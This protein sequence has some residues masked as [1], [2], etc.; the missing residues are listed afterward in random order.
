MDVMLTGVLSSVIGNCIS[1]F[2]K[3]H[4]E[5]KSGI[6]KINIENIIAVAISEAIEE[7]QIS[8]PYRLEEVCIYI[9]S[10]EVMSIIRQIFSVKLI[11]GGDQNNIT[12]IESEFIALFCLWFD[13]NKP[14]DTTKAKKIFDLILKAC[15]VGLDRAIELGILSAHDAKSQ[16]R[17]RILHDELLS[18][19]K[20]ISLIAENKD[21][22]AKDIFKFE[23][24][25][26][27]LVAGRYQYIVPPHFDSAKKIPID[28]LYVEPKFS[29]I[30]PK[31]QE[32]PLLD[33]KDFI[34][35]SYRSVVLGDPGSGKSTFTMKLCHDLASV[36]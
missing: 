19:K 35:N 11:Q 17:Y 32:S 16:F 12:E 10:P 18:I 21:L 7:V 13:R 24:R 9:G 6:K 28:K 15:D 36:V 14:E 34:S 33:G 31:S 29:R 4:Q 26:N 20:V 23:E 27:E 1:G 22:N 30:N 5:G 25:Y 3:F 8:P 2:T